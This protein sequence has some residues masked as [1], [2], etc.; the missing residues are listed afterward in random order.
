M[1]KIEE[2]LDYALELQEPQMFRVLLHNDDYTS[3][4]FVIEI[5]IDIF[6]KD[7]LQAE[8]TMI[9]I[10]EKGKAVCGIYTYEIAQ[11]KVEQV[12]QLAKKNEFPLLATM[13][14]V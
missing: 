8:Q 12:R 2:E 11:M 3:M 6:H 13:E 1:P 9:Q 10:H 7:H 4:D 5:L 14:E